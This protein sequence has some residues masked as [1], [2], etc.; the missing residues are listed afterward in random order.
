MLAYLS[1]CDIDC[2]INLVIDANSYDVFSFGSVAAIR[3]SNLI[4]S[5]AVSNVACIASQ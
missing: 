4:D 1:N 3:D 2:L 5:Y